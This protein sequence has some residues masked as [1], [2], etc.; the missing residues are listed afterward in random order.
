MEELTI[1]Q[2][3]N[4]VVEENLII[5]SCTHI[6]EFFVLDLDSRFVRPNRCVNDRPMTSAMLG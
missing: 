2:Y 4:Y 1:V 3:F 6:I 5:Q